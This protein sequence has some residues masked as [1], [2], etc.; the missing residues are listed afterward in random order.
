VFLAIATE[1]NYTDTA[2]LPAP[3][4]SAAWNYRAIYRL[5]DERVGQ[6]SDPVSQAVM[7]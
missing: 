4:Q 3:G 7:G 1:P 5:G 6:W 2:P